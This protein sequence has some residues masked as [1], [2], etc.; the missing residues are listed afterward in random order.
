MNHSNTL[1]A[2]AGLTMVLM[3]GVPMTGEPSGARQDHPQV[4]T[5]LGLVEGAAGSGAQAGIRAFKGIPYAAPPVGELRWQPPRPA[6][7]W[8]GVR[9]ATTFGPRCLQGRI[10]DDIVFRDE[11]SEDCLYLNVWTPAKAADER[12]P[13]MVWIHGG[14][15]QNGS[16]SEPR[17]DGER[18]AGKGVVVVS[19]NYRLGVFGFFAHPELTKESRGGGS[20]N[21][22]L[23]DQV[24]ALQWVRKNIAAF[25]GDPGNVTIFGES[26]GSFSVSAL[27][28]SPLANG[29][30]HKAI[31]ESGAYFAPV[32][33]PLP[34]K[35]LAESEEAGAKFGQ[36]I[37]ADTLAALRAKS[38]GDLVDAALKAAWFSPNVDGVVL[39]KAVIATF[40]AGAQHHVPLLAGWNADE[41]RGGVTLAKDK[42]TAARFIEQT[43]AKFRA[44]ADDVLK[45]YP[46]GT[47]AQAIESAAWLASD[48]FI[49]FST[50]KWLEMHAKTGGAAVFAYSFDRPVPIPP[51]TMQNGAPVTTRDMGARHAGE[52][53]YVFGTLDWAPTVPW[54]PADRALSDRMMSYWS[55]FART[56]DPNGQRLPPRGL[57]SGSL[58]SKDLPAWP[59]YDEKAGAAR[60][61]LHL[62]ETIKATP[63]PRRPRYELLDALESRRKS[64]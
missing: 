54:Q 12:L 58:P 63:D 19:F 22:G 37:G 34:L 55:N 11:P 56:G 17:Q 50:W 7:A 61:L 35:P 51:G 49:G 38:G 52:I 47:D 31:G 30:F 44:D 29:L 33:G 62:D 10:F 2:M 45:T 40:A 18:L 21:Y 64:A 60:E 13:V 36:A 48:L 20:G 4:K 26:A 32:L 6:A 46:A 25:G 57:P 24:A 1:M 23:F 3:K 8:E 15:F 9:K 39:P 14:G 59:R 53:E 5:E 41:A 42:M 16:G 28:A 43:R 27:M